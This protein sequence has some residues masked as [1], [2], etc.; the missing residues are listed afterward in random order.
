[1]E[2]QAKSLPQVESPKP[3]KK[4]TGIDDPL[5]LFYVEYL[6]SSLGCR[7]LL[8]VLSRDRNEQ[9]EDL[10]NKKSVTAYLHLASNIA[11]AS[12]SGAAGLVNRQDESQAINRI[13]LG[14]DSIANM[15]T[16]EYQDKSQKLDRKGELT[17]ALQRSLQE[18][19]TLTYRTVQ[20]LL[21]AEKRTYQQGIGA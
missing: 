11:V 7:K 18:G 12:A 14:I 8:E 20:D 19:D 21:E 9:K 3:E 5:V 4:P 2:I 17:S 13:G 1:M 15:H 16:G 10:A 6:K